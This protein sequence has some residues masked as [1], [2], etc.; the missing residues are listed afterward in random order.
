MNPGAKPAPAGFW[1]R[2]VAYFID[3]VLLCVVLLPL[4]RLFFPDWGAGEIDLLRAQAAST[5]MDAVLQQRAAV[6][7]HA[8]GFL[9][10]VTLWA[11]LAWMVVGGAWFVL[12]ESSAWQAT[13]GKRL[14]GIVVADTRGTRIGRRQALG[15]FF[16]A[17]LSWATLNIG[18]ALAM[19]APEHRA[20]HDYLAGTVVLDADPAHPQ[21]PWWAW[22]VVAAHVLALLVLIVM[23]VVSTLGAFAAA[24]AV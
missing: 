19:V 24:A 3:T 20:L 21:M 22:L 16:A 10:R 1:K 17:G 2:Y 8:L 15:R 12:F 4:F 11:A 7:Q 18:H 5:D 14:L 9:T 13:P 23:T 6:V